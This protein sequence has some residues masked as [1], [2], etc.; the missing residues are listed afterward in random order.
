MEV[1]ILHFVE[2]AKKAKGTAV[3]IDVFRAFS[4]E[5]YLTKNNA[6][7]IIPIGEIETA[8]EFK[9]ADPNVVLCGERRGIK[10]EG[11]DY[12][13]SP[14]QIE[15]VDFTGKTVIHTTSAGT[16][17]IVNATGADEII[18]GNLVCAKAIADYIKYTRPKHV[19]LVCM[20]LMGCRETDEDTLC[21]EYIKSLIEG[22][23][24]ADIEERIEN[25]KYTSGAQFFKPE[26]NHVFPEKD[27]ELCTRY[28]AFPF[29]LRLKKDENGGPA[30]MERIDIASLDKNYVADESKVVIPEIK[31][32][33]MASMLTREQAIC[34]PN[35]IKKELVYGNYKHPEEK[36]DA[37][38]VLGGDDT[39]MPSRAEAAAKLYHSGQCK[40]FITTGKICHNTQSGYITEAQALAEYMVN[41]GVPREC[42]LTEENATTTRENMKFSRQMLAE[43]YGNK[44]LEIA[45]VTS[46]FHL[47]RSVRLAKSHIENAEIYGVKADYPLDNPE[48]F[49]QSEMMIDRLKTES[50][51]LCGYAENG[52]IK[53]FPIL[54][55]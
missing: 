6:A 12:G 9:K 42:I 10:V 36:F 43:H 38:L 7:K 18:G 16:Q 5:T 22:K 4:L 29:V 23:P 11:F 8:F 55:K 19:S 21:A 32:G 31:H 17:G 50:R 47:N 40:L 39:L 54:Q 26:L 46:Y 45:I 27:F 33:D 41:A 15:N 14:A 25:L 28:S 20:G 34:L 48:Q 3:I 13:N 37:A 51:L 1:E 30:Y 2:G 44:K 35:D 53:D 52:T 24:L 49:Q